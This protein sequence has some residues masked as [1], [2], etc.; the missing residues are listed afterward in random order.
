MDSDPCYRTTYNVSFS[1]WTRIRLLFGVPIHV[2]LE[3]FEKS[4]TINLFVGV[5]VPKEKRKC[6][7]QTKQALIDDE[8][9][10]SVKTG[11]DIDYSLV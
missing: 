2:D 5:Y 8:L 6:A 1:L 9:W 3:R 4:R 10:S 7:A 11:N